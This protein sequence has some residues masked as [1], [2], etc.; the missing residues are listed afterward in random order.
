LI[1]D[2]K[3]GIFTH[4]DTVHVSQALGNDE[5]ATDSAAHMLE[6]ELKYKKVVV[7]FVFREH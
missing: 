5:V 7:F 1:S 4:E 6:R 3:Q 2:F